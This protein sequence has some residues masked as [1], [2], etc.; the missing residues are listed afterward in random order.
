[1]RENDFTREDSEQNLEIRRS[2][3]CGIRGMYRIGVMGRQI[4]SQL[5][6]G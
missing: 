5:G 1:L 3:H 4:Q 6:V 2:S